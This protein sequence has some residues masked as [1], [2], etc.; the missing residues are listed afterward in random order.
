M[1]HIIIFSG[2]FNPIHVGHL[3]LANYVAEF[4]NCD[5]VWLMVSPHNPLKDKVSLPDALLRYHWVEEVLKNNFKIKASGFEL[6]M[7]QPSYTFATLV[8]LQKTYPADRFS[9]LIGADN[10]LV[11]DQWKDY[12]QLINQFSIFIYPR[13]YAEIDQSKL[14]NSVK[15]ISAPIIE[16]S[17]S[18]IRQ[19][20][21][22]GKD[23][24]FFLPAQVWTEIK[25]QGLYI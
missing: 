11:F 24:R 9:L 18:M 13:L 21:S 19:S 5:E 6:S 2:S 3:M 15:I 12:Q 7:S 1:K 22:E 20:I 8:A 14:P 4:V 16:V 25:R 17:S 23:V 10:W